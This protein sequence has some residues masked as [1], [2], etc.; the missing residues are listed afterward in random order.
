MDAQQT[1]DPRV[2]DLVRAGRVRVALFP[3]FLYTKH[4]VTGELR[5]VG[6]EVARALA[7]RLGIEVLP[8]EYSS[9]PKVVEHLKAGACDVAFL[10]IDPSRI[11][12]VGF[13]P[14]LMEVDFTYLVP[15]ASSIRSVVDAD[16]SGVRIAVV[17]NHAMDFALSRILKQAQPVRVE[18]PDASFDLLR[19]GHADV[20]AGVRP[21]LLE[22]STQLT[23]SRVLAGRYGANRVAMVVP[24]DQP[25]RLAYIS[26]FIEEAKVSGLVQRVIER[27]GLHG[28]QVASPAKRNAQK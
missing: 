28:I 19:T 27:A 21:A 2:A 8:L 11:A 18:T 13:S 22:Y 26:D 10:G 12:E 23:G 16:R 24:K 20:Q 4:P 5:G 17:R 25:G 15:A 6:T 1:P 9:P 14:P 3:S 7:A